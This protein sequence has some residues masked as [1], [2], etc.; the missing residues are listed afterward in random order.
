VKNKKQAK[1]NKK[2]AGGGSSS[3]STTAGDTSPGVTSGPAAAV[4]P[5]PGSTPGT[6][7]ADTNPAATAPPDR[8][9][10]SRNFPTPLRVVP[11]RGPL[12]LGKGDVRG[13]I[14]PA[15]NAAPQLRGIRIRPLPR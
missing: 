12:P 6:P 3:S 9:P 15:A 10:L 13:R 11:Q 5:G 7:A 14:G 8:T 1:A 4:T 2:K